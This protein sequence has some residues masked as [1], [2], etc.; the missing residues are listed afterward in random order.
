MGE[1]IT[2]TT[3]VKNKSDDSTN[4]RANTISSLWQS[5]MKEGKKIFVTL[6]FLSIIINLNELRYR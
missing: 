5:S 6:N 3:I 2:P 1:M 4:S